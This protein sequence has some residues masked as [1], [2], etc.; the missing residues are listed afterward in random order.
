[1]AANLSKE[2]VAV[3]RKLVAL[4]KR[5]E[6]LAVTV[7][8]SEKPKKAKKVPVKKKAPAKKTAKKATAKKAVKKAAKKTPVKK[9]VAKK[10][11]KLS[12][13]D[14][15]LGIIQKSKNGMSVGALI[16][17]TG[18]NKKQISNVI[19]KLKKE[20]KVKNPKRGLYVKG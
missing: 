17:T 7:G 9:K 13:A 4:S 15:V 10:A 2:L 16:L 8:K 6:K 11:G 5:I 1:M 18:F 12:L 3:T 14:T 20:G 19:F